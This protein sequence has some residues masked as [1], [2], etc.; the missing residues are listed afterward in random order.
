[1]TL[2]IPDH[3]KNIFLFFAHYQSSTVHTDLNHENRIWTSQ[4][5]CRKEFMGHL[6]EV[7]KGAGPGHET[8]GYNKLTIDLIISLKPSF[9]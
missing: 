9:I 7:H 4:Y 2:D 8:R 5:N 6:L 1:M 3:N